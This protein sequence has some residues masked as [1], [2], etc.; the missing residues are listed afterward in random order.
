MRSSGIYEKHVTS[1]E[2]STQPVTKMTLNKDIK[3]YN[4][5]F[6]EPMR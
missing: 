3:N 2:L 1:V 5:I 6:Q 4:I